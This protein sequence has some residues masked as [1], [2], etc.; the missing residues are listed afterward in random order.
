[1][2]DDAISSAEDAVLT[3]DAISSAGEAAVTDLAKVTD[4]SDVSDS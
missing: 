3:D 1:L 4:L 2:S